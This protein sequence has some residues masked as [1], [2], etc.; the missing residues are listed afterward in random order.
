M[1]RSTLRVFR[2]AWKP[3]LFP[4]N[5]PLVLP[6]QNIEEETFP[7]YLASRYFPVR[8]GEII[9]EQYQV[10]GKLGYGA[11][12][13]V[14]LARDLVHRQHVAL[15]LFIHVAQKAKRGHPGRSALRQLL[16]SFDI[17]GPDGQ[18]R[19]LVHPPL[20][21]SVLALLY[22]NP[23]RKLPA[24]VVAVIL[25]CIFQALDFLHTECH[26]AHTDIK[27]DN[28]MC[29]I[30]PNDPTFATF[31]QEELQDPS[32]RKVLDGR[33]IYL[34]RELAIPEDLLNPLLCDFGSAVP[35]YDGR[36]H[37]ED[38]QPDV[39][40]APEVILEAP[41]TTNVDIW[42]VGCMIWH[43]FEG[44]HLFRGQDPEHSA[45]RSRAHL[46][47]MVALLGHPP[48]SLPARGNRSSEFFSSTGDF[49]TP[50]PLPATRT[51]E[52]R[53]TT[54]IG[55]EDGMAFLRLMRK[56]LQWEP[57]ERSSAK[58]LLGDEWIIKHTT[59]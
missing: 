17:K 22:R 12:S 48:K 40:R 2:S 51:L 58:E 54:L 11:T 13:T 59:S 32:L 41:W 9:H 53:E 15:K 20:W 7:G 56:M 18:H 39:Y 43:I 4:K 26:V 19:C 1:L 8:I 14:W 23:I 42:N 29:G 31:E 57:E 45:Y 46:A 37:R 24:S 38:I 44:E 52:D 21:D 27:A 25:K 33:Y 35:L 3:L 34:T 49:C 36:E 47:E 5:V 28:I 6:H 55:E 16:D 10:V 30:G 50:V